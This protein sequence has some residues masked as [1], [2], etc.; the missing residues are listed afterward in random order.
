MTKNET[1]TFECLFLHDT[2][3]AELEREQ[4]ALSGAFERLRKTARAERPDL[5]FSP[6]PPFCPATDALPSGKI[7]L[8]E[9]ESMNGWIIRRIQGADGGAI[10]E[11]PNVKDRSFLPGYPPL[12]DARCF[13][14]GF[15]GNLAL[16]VLEER[17]GD[18]PAISSKARYRAT[19]TLEVSRDDSFYGCARTI[20]AKRR[21]A[22]D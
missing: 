20:G 7:I 4:I 9:S 6:L 19:L 3:M 2:Q 17:V 8:G 14:L 18:S 12:P 10:R 13:I 16:A 11:D 5:P 22:A 15:A 1:S 21:E